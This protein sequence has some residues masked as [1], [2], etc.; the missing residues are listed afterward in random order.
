MLHKMCLFFVDVE[1]WRKDTVETLHRLI[2]QHVKVDQDRSTNAAP[3]GA[4]AMK[5]KATKAFV[6]RSNVAPAVEAMTRI[7][8]LVVERDGRMVQI[9]RTFKYRPYRARRHLGKTPLA[10]TE[11]FMR[12]FAC[13]G[14][15]RRW[16]HGRLIPADDTTPLSLTIDKPADDKQLARHY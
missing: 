6:R 11:L 14:P 9:R 1:F 3:A 13:G 15:R 10:R 7:R 2:C 8:D 16:R 5:K 12:S 4:P